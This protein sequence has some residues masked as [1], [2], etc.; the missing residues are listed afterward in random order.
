MIERQRQT[1]EGLGQDRRLGG[2]LPSGPAFQKCDG[3][4]RLQHIERDLLGP[5]G[6]IRETRGQQDLRVC[7]RQQ[8]GNLVRA[9]NIVIDKQ[10]SRSLRGKTA[11]SGLCGLFQIG[12]VGCDGAEFNG[13]GGQRSQ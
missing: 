9:R 12:L 1:T 4:C 6:P 2:V 8:F 7:S 11:Q 13:E 10:P 3:L 5:T